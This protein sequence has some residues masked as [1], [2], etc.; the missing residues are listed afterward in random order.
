MRGQR[1]KYSNY[2][3]T[4]IIKQK[5]QNTFPSAVNILA[6][7]WLTELMTLAESKAGTLPSCLH[8]NENL[9]IQPSIISLPLPHIITR[10]L[11]HNI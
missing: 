11:N 5:F 10:T 9:D 1:M 6:Q 3:M 4:V 8:Q 2:K 7:F